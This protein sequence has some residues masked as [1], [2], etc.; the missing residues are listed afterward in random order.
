MPKDTTR[1]IERKNG[2]WQP[3]FELR[4]V[5]SDRPGLKFL[6]GGM[7]GVIRAS[8]LL[9]EQN[10]LRKFNIEPGTT[11]LSGRSEYKA[12]LGIRVA[13]RGET[14]AVGVLQTHQYYVH[15]G[16]VETDYAEF[17]NLNRPNYIYSRSPDYG[18]FLNP[19]IEPAL[20]LYSTLRT[21]RSEHI[22]DLQGSKTLIIFSNIAHNLQMLD[23]LAR[24]SERGLS[25]GK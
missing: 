20:T 10:H 4:T 24:I 5:E 7:Y 13:I 8:H 15:I 6:F 18:V 1:G 3:V 12:F 19:K 23:T 22:G 14:V 2:N 9:D 25:Q 11:D 16:P 17:H 21:L